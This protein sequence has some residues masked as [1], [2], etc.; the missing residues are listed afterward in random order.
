[1]VAL[2]GTLHAH[3][4]LNHRPLGGVCFAPHLLHHD[5][6]DVLVVVD[7]AGLECIE[8]ELGAVVHVWSLHHELRGALL[9]LTF[10]VV[11]LGSFEVEVDVHHQRH[12]PE[13]GDEHLISQ[14]LLGRFHRLA[15][16]GVDVASTLEPGWLVGLG[17]AGKNEACSL[18]Y[19]GN[20][21][22]IGCGGASN[23]GGLVSGGT[24][25]WIGASF[26]FKC[27][28]GL[29]FAMRGDWQRRAIFSTVGWDC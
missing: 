26:F 23:A 28:L 1:M 17:L 16:P 5:L 12:I 27:G 13:R 14:N 22:R 20:V 2:R 4:Q 11:A 10:L 8:H 29:L 25:H 6:G 18:C 3:K 19:G 21:L 9:E 24:F 15:M 7:Y